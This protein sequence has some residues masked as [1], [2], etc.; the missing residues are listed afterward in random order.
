M[1]V[2]PAD[3]AAVLDA[4]SANEFHRDE[5]LPYWVEHWPC[6]DVLLE[7]VHRHPPRSG[8]TVVEIGAGLGVLSALAGRTAARSVAIEI[9]FD[10]CRYCRVNMSRNLPGFLVIQGDWRTPALRPC[11]DLVLASD[12]LY[13]QRW[14]E[15][16]LG[17][18]AALLRSGGCALVADPGRKWW[19]EFLGSAHKYGLTAQV[20]HRGVINNGK[21]TV[22]IA[23]LS[24]T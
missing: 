20:A 7:W 4:I 13:E 10:G 14:V 18:C 1:F 3:P 11:A 9:F 2:R 15:P 23:R 8:E 22:T 21:T 5:Q 6:A 16:V 24:L 12:V 19:G 17:C